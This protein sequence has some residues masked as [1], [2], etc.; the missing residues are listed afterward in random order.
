MG[1]CLETII[2][3]IGVFLSCSVGEINRKRVEELYK[4]S[5]IFYRFCQE[6]EIEEYYN[7]RKF[8]RIPDLTEDEKSFLVQFILLHSKNGDVLV[9]K[10]YGWVE[11]FHGSGLVRNF[12]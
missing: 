6:K 1:N 12:Y 9:N 7:T 8:D 10:Q 4:T 11:Y 3:A 2:L 5:H